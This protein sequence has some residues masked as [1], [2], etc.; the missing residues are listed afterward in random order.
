M[1]WK[2]KFD[3]KNWHQSLKFPSWKLMEESRLNNYNNIFSKGYA[4]NW[5]K[6]MFII[7]SVLKT[8]P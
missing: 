5:W 3:W 1:G 6:E 8:N 4:E 2:N 7:D